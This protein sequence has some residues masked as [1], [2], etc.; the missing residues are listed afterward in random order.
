[1][2]LCYS[3]PSSRTER[4]IT[5]P[6]RRV[7]R[8]IT[9]W[10]PSDL[11][12]LLVEVEI[13]DKNDNPPRFTKKWFTAGVTKDT[14]FGEEVLD[15]K[16]PTC[17]MLLQCQKTFCYCSSL[18]KFKLVYVRLSSK[19]EFCNKVSTISAYALS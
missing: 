7:A 16:V 4:E 13:T 5:G 6:S 18:Y 10:D 9:G 11:S 8:E 3:G 12:L 2:I 14:Q 15:F 1:M 17:F 19:S